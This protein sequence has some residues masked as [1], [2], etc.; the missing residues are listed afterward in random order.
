MRAVIVSLAVIAL[1][2]AQGKVVVGNDL[3]IY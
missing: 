2:P 3:D 1:Q